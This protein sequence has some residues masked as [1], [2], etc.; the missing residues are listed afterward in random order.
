M[1][2]SAEIDERTNTVNVYHTSDICDDGD[3]ECGVWVGSF[4][5]ELVGEDVVIHTWNFDEVF[6]QKSLKVA[7]DT[8]VE[9]FARPREVKRILVERSCADRV[10]LALGWRIVGKCEMLERSATICYT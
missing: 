2:W 6:H 8:F 4:G 10:W 3:C 7:V 1:R 5:F 9:K